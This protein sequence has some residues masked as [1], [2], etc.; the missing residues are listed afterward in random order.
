MTSTTVRVIYRQEEG[1]WSFTSPD[2]PGWIGGGECFEEAR[3]LAEEG[4]GFA[5]GITDELGPRSDVV[6]E[7]YVPAP[8]S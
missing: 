5:L 6:L 1:R 4:A 7:H 8:A 3:A 2:I